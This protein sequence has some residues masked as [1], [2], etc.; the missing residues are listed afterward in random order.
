MT[1]RPAVL[2]TGAAGLVGAEVV[3]RLRRQGHPVIALAHRRTD[4]V[5]VAGTQHHPPTFADAPDAPLS[6]LTGDVTQPGFGLPDDLSAALTRRIG[7]I[8]HSAATTDF[9]APDD[10]YSTLN[11]G[12]TVN[13]CTLAERWEARL[14]YVSTAYVCGRREGRIAEDDLDD[15]AGFGNGYEHSKFTAESHV[16]SRDIPWTVVRPGIVT[17]CVDTGAIRDR[18]NLY[19]VVRLI[20]E[21]KLRTL[22]GRYDATLAPAPVDFVADVVAAA[23]DQEDAAHGR[24]FHAVGAETLSLRAM[25]DVFAEYPS[26]EVAR[27]VPSSSFHIDDLDPLER[28][29]FERIGYQ[30]VTYFD[31][32][33]TFSTDSVRDILGLTPPPT[34]DDYLR[35]LLDNSLDVGFLGGRPDLLEDL[36]CSD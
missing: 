1:D 33:R 10:L 14:V 18:R 20:V 35:V 4:I 29:Y 36:R 34:G 25:S 8:V 2:V 27:F 30:Y 5:D 23:V 28:E 6:M 13:A 17:G 31:R 22:P 19:T 21:G 32:N 26:F 3:T 15:S 12:G 7:T 24:T 9:D 11:V 16:R